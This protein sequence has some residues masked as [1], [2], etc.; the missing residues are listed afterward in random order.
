MEAVLEAT[1][2]DTFGKNEARRTRVFLRNLA[3]FG[4]GEP[5]SNE[6]RAGSASAP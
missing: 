6:V 2:R 3:R 5:L 4:R 1:T